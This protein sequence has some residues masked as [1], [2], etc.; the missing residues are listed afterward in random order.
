[1]QK[2][3]DMINERAK[4]PE[5]G[6]DIARR[7]LNKKAEISKRNYIVGFSAVVSLI[8]MAGGMYL[9]QI[10]QKTMLKSNFNYILS[11]TLSVSNSN[12]VISK[13]I[14]EKIIQYCMNTK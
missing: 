11:E 7:V 5:W 13:D 14:D 1:M 3:E 8:A 9:Y 12:T 2:I 6:K 10:N 4:S